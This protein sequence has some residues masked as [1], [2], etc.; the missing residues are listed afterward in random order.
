MCFPNPERNSSVENS[1]Y[2]MDVI[3]QKQKVFEN[4]DG[5]LYRHARTLASGAQSWRGLQKYCKDRI[6]LHGD[7]N[8]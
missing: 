6:Y 2:E 3:S 5:Y 1:P 7:G 8:N 4:F